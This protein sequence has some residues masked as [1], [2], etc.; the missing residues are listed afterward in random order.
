[1]PPPSP[2]PLMY[3]LHNSASQQISDAA[4]PALDPQAIVCKLSD[5]SSPAYDAES[6][7]KIAVRE[8]D[9]SIKDYKKTLI[10][11]E[12]TPSQFNAVRTVFLPLRCSS[13]RTK[14]PKR[15]TKTIKVAS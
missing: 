9:P 10:L 3:Y 15:P 14:G 11:E 4:S 8:A 12:P 1:M 5:S 13:Q 6:E 7:L 2:P